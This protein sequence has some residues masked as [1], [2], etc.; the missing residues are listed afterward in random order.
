MATGDGSNIESESG[1]APG[2]VLRAY[3]I[4][5]LANAIACLA[6]RGAR[7]H[8]GVH[9]ARKSM[10]RTRAALALGGPALGRGGQMIDDEIQRVVRS[11]SSLRDAQALVEALQRLTEKD[12]APTT[13]PLLDRARRAAVRQRMLRARAVV[14]DDN[15]FL[16]ESRTLL[17]VLAA[18][19]RTLSWSGVRDEAVQAA[20]QRSASKAGT[21]S[22][23]AMRS[24]RDED[25][26]RWRR[27]AR[28]LSQQHRALGDPPGSAL[29]MDKS[30]AVLLGEAQDYAL[31]IDHCGADSPFTFPD[32]QELRAI[33][34][35][36]VK[37]LRTKIARTSSKAS[38]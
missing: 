11:L 17:T 15:T 8:A 4:N 30:L 2:E 20:L 27:R 22:K 24:G 6:W 35:K 1:V 3:A 31:L 14:R 37:R 26:H 13:H 38:S 28:R 5:E 7:L 25:W 29:A 32:R 34:G 19:L 16:P 23:R 10:R 36:R 18:G 21:A 12:Q 9:Q 33:A